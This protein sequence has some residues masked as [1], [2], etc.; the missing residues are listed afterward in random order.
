MAFGDNENDREM[1][2]LV[3]H[4]YIMEHCNLSILDIPAKRC[5]RVEDVL[6]ELLEKERQE[7]GI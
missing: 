5:S 1:L 7:K 6:R 4:P 3:G 2:E